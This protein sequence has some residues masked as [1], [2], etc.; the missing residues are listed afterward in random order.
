MFS[1]KKLNL[2]PPIIIDIASNLFNRENRDYQKDAYLARLE[3]T[4]EYIEYM[5]SKYNKKK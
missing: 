3:A 4:K 2:V 1:E 5:T